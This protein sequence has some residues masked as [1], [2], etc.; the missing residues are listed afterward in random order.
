MQSKVNGKKRINFKY[1]QEN[2]LTAIFMSDIPYFHSHCHQSVD[3]HQDKAKKYT[4]QSTL[5]F[6]EEKGSKKQE[7]KL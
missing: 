6:V 2:I 3:L 4:S 7:L 5:A 1:F